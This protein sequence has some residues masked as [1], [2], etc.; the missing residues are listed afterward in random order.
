MAAGKCFLCKQSGHVA[1][2][3]P[4]A[5]NVRSTR[6]GK[7]PGVDIHSIEL[8]LKKVDSLRSAAVALPTVDS[9]EVSSV[10][11]MSSSDSDDEED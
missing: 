11:S 3:C 4:T 6:S 7:P 2:Q 10:V 1:W 8:D 5:N 9:L